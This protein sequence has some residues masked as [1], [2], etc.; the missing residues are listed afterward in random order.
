MVG[1]FVTSVLEDRRRKLTTG[2]YRDDPLVQQCTV[3]QQKLK[4]LQHTLEV[5]VKGTGERLK[6]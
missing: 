4:G 5:R 6:I 1:H 3:L 2:E